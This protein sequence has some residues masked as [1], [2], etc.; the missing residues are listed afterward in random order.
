MIWLGITTIAVFI[1]IVY[2]VIFIKLHFILQAM[3]KA[4]EYN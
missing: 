3:G 1:D 2:E 4:D